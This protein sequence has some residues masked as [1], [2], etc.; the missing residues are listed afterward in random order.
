MKF[1]SSSKLRLPPIT[2]RILR[3][4]VRRLRC[5][6]WALC[7]ASFLLCFGVSRADQAA[8]VAAIL[9][10]LRRNATVNDNGFYTVPLDTDDPESYLSEL[11]LYQDKN[12]ANWQSETVV[13][14]NQGLFSG[15]V[16]YLSLV[17]T[18][19][20]AQ[21]S[22][23]TNL[24]EFLRPFLETLDSNTISIDGNLSSIRLDVGRIYDDVVS[25]SSLV[26]Y[27]G[28][29][30]D[31]IR[32]DDNWKVHDADLQ[33]ALV[34]ALSNNGTAVNGIS[35]TLGGIS[36]SASGIQDTLSGINERL[37]GINQNWL[38]SHSWSR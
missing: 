35:E 24:V 28:A 33:T 13:K 31:N 15:Q 17:L 20:Q 5:S 38:A 7:A 4:G 10:L 26:S 21:A 3:S 16:P 11:L 32:D 2:P 19:L 36:E 27:Y 14:L 22:G 34:D 23:D 25:I 1:P 37:S 30:W 18:A 8:D 9:D 6:C 12:V 29:L